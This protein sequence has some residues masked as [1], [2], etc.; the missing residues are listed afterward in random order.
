MKY[1]KDLVKVGEG[2]RFDLRHMAPKVKVAL[3]TSMIR[4]MV[5]VAGIEHYIGPLSHYRSIAEIGPGYGDFATC[6]LARKLAIAQTIHKQ[7]NT[8]EEFSI[9]AATPDMYLYDLPHLLNLTF[10]YMSNF[11]WVKEE[12]IHYMPSVLASMPE[13]MAESCPLSDD[14]TT[15]TVEGDTTTT[16]TTS[17][18]ASTSST[19]TAQDCEKMSPHRLPTHY[20]LCVSINAVSMLS[21]VWQVQYLHKV[22]KYCDRGYV[23][24]HF[25]TR[26]VYPT[27]PIKDFVDTLKRLNPRRDVV[28]LVHHPEVESALIMWK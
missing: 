4:S 20:D 26:E 23:V 25:P 28:T 9:L 24:F 21:D 5:Y 3:E 6:F 13:D 17:T 15:S 8:T 16:S 19:Q 2:I 22:L 1:I 11:S 10:I 12:K 18:T 27:L 7:A 14:A